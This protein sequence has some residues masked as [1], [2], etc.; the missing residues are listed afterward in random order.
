M[1]TTTISNPG[2]NTCL[3]TTNAVVNGTYDANFKVVPKV[4]ADTGVMYFVRAKV[5]SDPEKDSPASTDV[6]KN[7]SVTFTSLTAA[8]DVTVTAQLMKSVNGGAAVPVGNP[9]TVAHVTVPCSN[10]TEDPGGI[11]SKTASTTAPTNKSEQVAAPKPHRHL[12]IYWTYDNAVWGKRILKA[13]GI[14][15]RTDENTGATEVWAVS[16]GTA[17]NGVAT[18]IIPIPHAAAKTTYKRYI[19]LF[20]RIDSALLT[21]SPVVDHPAE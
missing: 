15:L 7:W 2:A 3:P 5:G 4:T 6:S 20:S 8:A 18:A 11:F 13:V 16:E 21:R 1:A 19:A 17:H 14:V 9:A 10:P 12:T